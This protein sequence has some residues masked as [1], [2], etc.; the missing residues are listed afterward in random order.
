MKKPLSPQFESLKI[1]TNAE[2]DR[3]YYKPSRLE[4]RRRLF[5]IF[6]QIVGAQQEYRRARMASLNSSGL[7]TARTN[8]IPG[9]SGRKCS[10][11]PAFRRSYKDKAPCPCGMTARREQ[12]IDDRALRTWPP[13]HFAAMLA[14]IR[15]KRR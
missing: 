2:R 15:S 3:V 6:R 7:W 9:G 8:A 12:R 1:Y 5:R 14:S 4:A 10:R 11:C 13:R